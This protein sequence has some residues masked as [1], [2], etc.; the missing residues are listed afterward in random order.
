M[1][2]I[3]LLVR[4]AEG[5]TQQ[6]RFETGPVTL[7]RSETA[8]IVFGDEG[9][10][11]VHLVIDLGPQ[12]WTVT[13]EGR[14]HPAVVDGRTL[15][16][17]GSARIAD[18]TVITVGTTGITLTARL[19]GAAGVAAS[20][21]APTV[22]GT[23]A[24]QMRHEPSPEEIERAQHHTILPGT[25]LRADVADVPPPPT[26]DEAL[27]FLAL[28]RGATPD[29]IHTAFDTRLAEL[30]RRRREAPTPTL[31]DKYTR[32]IEHRLPA[33]RDAALAAA[34]VSSPPFPAKGGG[35]R[36]L[37]ANAPTPF[38]AGAGRPPVN[39]GDVLADRFEL[40]R[41]LG[42][43]GMGVVFEAYD[44]TRMERVALKIVLP[45]LAGSPEARDRL[46]AEGRIASGLTHPNIV[47]VHDLHRHGDLVFITM[48]ML[49]GGTL[50]DEITHAARR[51]EPFTVARAVAV[52][53]QI[54]AALQHAHSSTVHRDVKPENVWICGSG[55]ATGSVKLMDFGIAR[56]LGA[57]Q[58]TA[59]GVGMGTAYYMAPEQMTDAGAVTPAADQYST[60]IV[61]YELLAGQ[62]PTGRAQSL[63]AIRDDVPRALSD[64][65][66]RA[67]SPDPAARFP[68]MDAFAAAI[69]GKKAKRRSPVLVALLVLIAAAGVAAAMNADRIS[70][71]V[72]RWRREPLVAERTA[73]RATELRTKLGALPEWRRQAAA[74]KIAASLA[75]AEAAL[76]DAR[77]DDAAET[78]AAAASALDAATARAE[79]T[80]LAAARCAAMADDVARFGK[81]AA[82]LRATA[83]ER[84][85]SL[86]GAMAG[87]APADA[88]AYER[89]RTSVA[90]LD[91]A[92]ARFAEELGPVRDRIAAAAAA[93]ATR[94][95]AGFDTGETETQSLEAV[96]T[97]HAAA[98]AKGGTLDAAAS[99]AL[100]R[101]AKAEDAER[102]RQKSFE[103]EAIAA[104]EKVRERRA[105]LD[106]A[107]AAD[108]AEL[109]EAETLA[110]MSPQTPA[111]KTLERFEDGRVAAF[112]AE[113]LRA[114]ADEF[115]ARAAPHLAAAATA[116]AAGADAAKRGIFSAAVTSWTKA[117]AHLDTALAF[118]HAAHAAAAATAKCGTLPE[119]TQQAATAARAAADELGSGDA[120]IAA[121]HLADPAAAL[122]AESPKARADA[123]TWKR[124]A[125]EALRCSRCFQ[126]PNRGRCQQCKGGG[127]ITV[128]C[129][130]CKGSATVYDPCDVC[131]A[132]GKI[133][134]TRCS[135]K[136]TITN[137]CS[138]CGGAGTQPCA[139]CNGQGTQRCGSCGGAGSSQCGVCMG[140]G[141]RKFGGYDL[142][143]VVCELDGR[144]DCKSCLGKGQTTCLGCGGRRNLDCRNAQCE[145]GQVTIDCERCD[146][147]KYTC[148][149]C[150]GAKQNA[151][152]CPTCGS[153]T[154]Q[155]TCP[156]CS[157]AR[158]CP[159]CR[160][161][162]RRE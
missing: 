146:K 10:S 124:R 90:D 39:E 110:R 84:W 19:L 91:A 38:L 134:C 64:A 139:Q 113:M 82:A 104:Q 30:E 128:K 116:D 27:Q 33:A 132:S 145:G 129:D 108:A 119:A 103:P 16:R 9:V 161:T 74:D 152:H 156:E 43:G 120:A 42:A 149:R 76:A 77:D 4:D 159:P 142:P 100:E 14:W 37:S 79:T 69:A 62:V 53:T 36:P 148:E 20:R 47:K 12:G 135:A 57:R 83:A 58:L 23:P 3:D 89:A 133:N 13:Q 63:A 143:C 6:H 7:G 138:T 25:P 88:G 21:D 18:R 49:D 107:V 48:E 151:R 78:L 140:A 155:K 126:A 41:R 109:A 28:G 118:L 56:A 162:G 68:S 95:D 114:A 67:L 24:P 46:V 22:V 141:H 102:A 32:D 26:L 136:G 121:I 75:D 55:P 31:R 122:A 115:N 65:V 130:T 105:A 154:V 101:I 70:L 92:V 86:V 123:L 150:K 157:G 137:P 71:E 5:R 17:G 54:A 93:F 8:D 34:H 80:R 1:G 158:E 99:T 96:L 66:D 40:R 15:D 2:A 50:R 147:G 51:G 153:G 61:L 127:E 11:R 85:K 98:L 112:R 160:G 72:R 87:A 29:Q 106:A 144:I 44:R 97:E 35:A 94:S 125:E 111:A 73:K 131:Q 45:A 81:D 52:V 60:A 59:T 117:A